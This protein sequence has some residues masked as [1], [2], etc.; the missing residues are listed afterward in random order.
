M[1]CLFLKEKARFSLPVCLIFSQSI[2]VC[3]VKHNQLQTHC[4]HPG[5]VPHY[6]GTG[7]GDDPAALA[8]AT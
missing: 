3:Y 7:D 5:N 2:I 8:E 6:Y 4:H 1:A